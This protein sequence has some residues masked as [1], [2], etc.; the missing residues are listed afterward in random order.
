MSVYTFSFRPSL[1]NYKEMLVMLFT[2]TVSLPGNQDAKS[3]III[4]KKIERLGEHSS[5]FLV[6]EP[7]EE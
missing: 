2:F 4:I 6:T 7:R 1:Y 5:R 3:L